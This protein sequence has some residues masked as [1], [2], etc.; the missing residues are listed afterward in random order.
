[1]ALSVCNLIRPSPITVN[2][3]NIKLSKA[4]NDRIRVKPKILELNVRRVDPEGL[5]LEHL[6]RERCLEIVKLEIIHI[7]VLNV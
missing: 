1:M 3:E 4:P 7:T 6:L 2:I 5:V